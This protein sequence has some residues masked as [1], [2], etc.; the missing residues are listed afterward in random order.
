MNA[1]NAMHYF[2]FQ[3]EHKS[4]IL[5]YKSCILIC[6]LLYF[7]NDHPRDWTDW[8]DWIEWIDWTDWTVDVDENDS[9]DVHVHVDFDCEYDW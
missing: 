8:I 3:H 2:R 9:D 4:C 5:I 6:F 1:M 7:D